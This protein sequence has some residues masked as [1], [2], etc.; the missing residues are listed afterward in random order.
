MNNSLTIPAK[1]I[2]GEV[3]NEKA[4]ELGLVKLD[5]LN[6]LANQLNEIIEDRERGYQLLGSVW[7]APNENF[8]LSSSSAVVESIT[9][10]EGGAIY[11][12]NQT[13]SSENGAYIFV[14]G[15]WQRDPRMNEQAE[16]KTGN[17]FVIEGGT[18]ANARVVI[19]SVGTGPNTSHIIGTDAIVGEIKELGTYT[20]TFKQE[21]GN[22]TQAITDT[23]N[24]SPV[25]TGFVLAKDYDVILS[26]FLENTP[27][28]PEATVSSRAF[29]TADNGTTA[30]KVGEYK[31]GDE[32]YINASLVNTTFNVGALVQIS[33]SKGRN[34]YVSKP[35]HE[36]NGT[37]LRFENTD[38]TWGNY[39]ELKGDTGPQGPTGLQGPIG[40][41]GDQGNTG[42]TGATGAT[43]PRP[44]H[45][46][47]GSSLRFQNSN[48]S[49]GSYVNLQGAQ[50]PQGPQG[51]PGNDS[52]LVYNG[53]VSGNFLISS[54]TSMIRITFPGGV[55][56]YIPRSYSTL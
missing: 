6:Q 45:Q 54:Q 32:L 40:P 35:Q 2:T 31:V 12:N 11:L 27:L 50:G 10:P 24:P 25:P 13:N 36:W 5:A 38:G 9:I 4:G 51:L 44:S 20:V 26:L 3:S 18:Y 19:T 49:W 15:S 7:V 46:W 30:K 8:D 53:V 29:F 33:G 14:S 1:Q 48:G 56:G 34:G 52:G 37:K 43:G 17:F 23:N 42:A 47:S 21:Q 22:T 16:V 55:V 41:K 28:I 39:V